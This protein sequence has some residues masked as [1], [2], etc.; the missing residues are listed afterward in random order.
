DD[1][2]G[3]PRMEPE[4]TRVSLHGGECPCCA[5]R[6][7]AEPPAGL[8]PGSPFGPNIRALVIYLR[9]VQGIPLARLRTVLADLFGL[10][11][12]EG[13]LVNILAASAKQFLSAP[14]HIKARLIAGACMSY[15]SWVG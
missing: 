2:V 14:E 11:I 5:R 12:S 4:G 1:R 13:A 10:A 6:F 15:G 8:E 3:S 9:S 7:K